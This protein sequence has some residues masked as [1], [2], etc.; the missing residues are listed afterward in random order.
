MKEDYKK[1]LQ[2][3]AL[4]LISEG[5]VD[6]NSFEEGKTYE[7]SYKVKCENKHL[8]L[9]KCAEVKL[10]ENGKD[11]QVKCEKNDNL[12]I[13]SLA[14]EMNDYREKLRMH[15][16]SSLAEAKIALESKELRILLCGHRE[17]KHSASF[18][19]C[20]CDYG[21]YESFSLEELRALYALKIDKQKE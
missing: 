3:S 7:I 4:T 11:L 13:S 20:A 21:E 16:E 17:R 15:Q 10:L 19:E 12:N 18:V 1:Y 2:R 8:N 14:C 5:I 6:M 9:V